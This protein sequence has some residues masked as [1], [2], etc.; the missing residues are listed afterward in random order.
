MFDSILR[1]SSLDENTLNDLRAVLEAEH[2]SLREELAA[3]GK[4][5]DGNWQ[6][7]ASGLAGEEP[8]PNDAADKIEELVTN[9]PLVEELESRL[10]DVSGTL[11]KM[12]KGTYGVCEVGGEEIPLERLRA[13]PAARTCVKHAANTR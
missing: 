12:E 9:V 4:L 1:M 5:L 11:E 10:K 7:N 8:D 2:D 13:N 3:H 6:G